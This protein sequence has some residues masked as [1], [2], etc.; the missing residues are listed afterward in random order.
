MFG[1]PVIGPGMEANTFGSLGS[2]LSNPPTVRPILPVIGDNTLS[3]GHG[4][5]AVGGGEPRA[6][7]SRGRQERQSWPGLPR[8]SPDFHCP[9]RHS[10]GESH[11]SHEDHHADGPIRSAVVYN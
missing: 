5:T 6:W 8:S 4:L 9:H 1:T 3:G 7:A 11:R 10:F 2:T